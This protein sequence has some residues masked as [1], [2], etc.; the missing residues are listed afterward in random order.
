MHGGMGWARLLG[1]I[2]P[3]LR[4]SLA[5]VHTMEDTNTGDSTS[6]GDISGPHNCGHALRPRG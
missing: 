6:S 5:D 1:G 3:G 2:G 4:V